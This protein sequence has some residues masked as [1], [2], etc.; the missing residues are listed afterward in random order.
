MKKLSLLLILAFVSIGL[1]ACGADDELPDV[2]NEAEDAPADEGEEISE[3]VEDRDTLIMATSADF[4]PFE[5]RNTDGDIVGFDIDLAHHI[6]DELGYELEIRDMSFDG[7]I[8]ALQS[9]RADMVLSGMSATDDR[10]E[11]VDFSVE[12]H[13]SG[14]MFIT[15][16]D[17]GIEEIDDI[18]GTT[19]G[20]QLGTIQQEGAEAL[21]EDYDFEIS[22]LDD[23]QALIQELLSNRIDVVYLDRAVA[24][25]FIESQDLEGFDDPTRVSPGM[26]VAFP[27][28]SDLV[29][30]VDAV[31]E[32]A[33]ESGFIDE[34][35]DEWLSDLDEEAE[36]EV[37]EFEEE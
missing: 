18:E 33:L 15:R 12:Y 13:R 32:E 30:D 36:E 19:V 6:A 11:N 25:G 4:P 21:Q 17:S 23:A 1:I 28:G 5:S 2:E 14:E 24:T 35:E 3:D 9:D 8:G 34:L 27:K 7:L 16:Q 37:E 29:D 31:I 10:R 20:V 22:A 26:A